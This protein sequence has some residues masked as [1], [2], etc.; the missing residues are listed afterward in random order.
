M[1]PHLIEIDFFLSFLQVYINHIWVHTL[2]TISLQ[3]SS[4]QLNS[5]R[6]SKTMQI[7]CNFSSRAI[8]TLGPWLP[9]FYGHFNSQFCL[10][11]PFVIRQFC[12]HTKT[13]CGWHM[14][15]KHILLVNQ[16]VNF[17]L[18]YCRSFSSISQAEPQKF[19]RGHLYKLPRNRKSK[20]YNVQSTQF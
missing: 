19:P 4:L 17:F 16:K 7:R 8:L 1:L 2:F 3:V 9:D 14:S 10:G 11:P 13:M 12:F 5:I 6:K 18:L 20:S 15:F